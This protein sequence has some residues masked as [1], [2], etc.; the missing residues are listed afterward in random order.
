M[1]GNIKS[2]AHGVEYHV[3]GSDGTIIM[4]GGPF[5]GL[6]TKLIG[7]G[8]DV[9]H[10]MPVRVVHN[11]HIAPFIFDPAYAPNAQPAPDPSAVATAAAETKKAIEVVPEIVTEK[12]SQSTPTEASPFAEIQVATFDE[13]TPIQLDAPEGGAAP[14]AG[15]DLPETEAIGSEKTLETLQTRELKDFGIS[16]NEF[17]SLGLSKSQLWKLYEQ[18][19]G[20]TTNRPSVTIAA[21]TIMK[22]ANAN[23]ADYTRVVQAISRIIGS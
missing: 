5:A 22:K 10:G 23:A 15:I 4:Q 21:Q 20:R 6:R 11:E 12:F 8:I 14:E 17:N 18:V 19:I 3:A 1:N 2:T 9:R 13:E 16:V 7:Q